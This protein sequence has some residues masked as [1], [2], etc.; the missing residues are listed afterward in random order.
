MTVAWL[1]QSNLTNAG[2]IERLR[3][4]LSSMDNEATQC[5]ILLALNN[6]ALNEESITHFSV[7]IQL[8]FHNSWKRCGF[9]S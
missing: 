7:G 6:L 2:C 4:L 9:F 1:D 5:K 3:E 8:L